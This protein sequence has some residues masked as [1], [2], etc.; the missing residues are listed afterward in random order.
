VPIFM[1]IKA[2]FAVILILWIGSVAGAGGKKIVHLFLKGTIHP[3]TAEYVTKA[4]GHAEE[5]H[6]EVVVFQIETPGGLS[7][8]MRTIISTMINSKVPVIVYVAPS[9]SRATSAGF[10]IAVASDL[11]VM[12]PGTH[13]GSAHPVTMGQEGPDTENSKTMMKKV[14]ED[15]VAYIKTLAERR[16]RNVEQAEKA[17]RDSISFTENEALKANLINFVAGNLQDLLQKAN[18][19]TI[20]RFDGST[21]KLELENPEVIEFEM[22]RRQKFLSLLAD[23]NV[24]FML[25]GLGM[26]GLM[27]ELYN[28]G[29]ILPGI[30]G[31]ISVAL[32]LLSVQVLPINYAG[33]FLIAFA[34]VLF[35]LE[36]KITSYGILTL[37]GIVSI[38][39]GATMLIDAPIPEMK[40]AWR[41][42]L[43]VV[44]MI[45]ATMTFLLTLVVTLH[46]MKPVTG[47]QGML[48][49][50]GIAQTRIDREGQVFVRGE[51]W[52]AVA[53]KPIEKGEKVKVLSV[54]GLTLQVEKWNETPGPEPGA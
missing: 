34:I 9:G 21:K 2:L 44:A 4:I 45:A 8:S 6:A 16:G 39:L 50:I 31:V 18:G 32:F 35:V 7:E 52:N 33:L 19:M 3:I 40:I 47:V 24:A 1:K 54:H 20:R 46:R 5:T 26:L 53:S 11:A 36:I 29:L 42:I 22:T 25:I 43:T 30:V 15:S 13:L 41:V 17:V 12:A 10:Y 23:P 37:G 27:I 48:Q 28:P 14:T 49:E 51:I 38:I